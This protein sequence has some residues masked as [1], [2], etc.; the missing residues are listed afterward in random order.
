META[1]ASRFNTCPTASVTNENR[2]I[3]TKQL[4]PTT[5]FLLTGFGMTLDAISSYRSIYA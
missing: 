2:K 3:A 1:S 4:F 5:L